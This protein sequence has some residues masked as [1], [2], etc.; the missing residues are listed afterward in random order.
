M[1]KGRDD[2]FIAHFYGSSNG[3]IEL[4]NKQETDKVLSALKDAIYRVLSVKKGNKSKTPPPPFITSTMQQ[5]A[6]RK[7]NFSAKRTMQAAQQ[8]YEGVDIEGLGSVGLI[9]YMRTD[10]L[11]ISDEARQSAAGYIKSVFG[12]KYLPEKPRYYKSKKGVQDA[13]EAIR[14]TEIG[15]SPDKVKIAKPDLYKLYKLIWERFV[16]SQMQ[17]ATLKR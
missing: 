12:D 2:V 9:T 13:H 5:E 6:S 1:Q 16:A 14:L 10:S 4:K 15:L 8:L 17:N 11:R 3:K 7:L